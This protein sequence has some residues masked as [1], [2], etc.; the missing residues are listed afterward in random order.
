MHER[1]CH[2]LAIFV[3]L[4]YDPANL[5]AG[6][7]L[8]KKHW[9]DFAKR[10]RKVHAPKKL[11]FFHCGEYGENLSRPHYHAILYGIDFPDKIR[12]SKTL[13]GD[14][15]YES[16]TLNDIWGHGQ[17][18]IGSVT[19][20]SARYVAA[21]C[22]KKVNG[23]KADAHYSRPDADGVLHQLEPE[24]STQSK[25]LGLAWLKRYT[26]DVFPID[27][28]VCEGRESPVPRYYRKKLAEHD[29]QTL[30]A[31]R[32]G[33]SLSKRLSDNRI[34]AAK[35]RAPDNTPE[36]LAVKLTVRLSKISQLKRTL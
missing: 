3:T 6:G 19:F 4:T 29:E 30:P 15:L 31:P 34:K 21:Y 24:Y 22:L 1:Q 35:K 10:L 32:Y 17:C 14:Q 13:Q 26:S 20:K 36:R 27:S 12:Y 16:K 28:V 23:E 2:D 25:G 9:Q 8:V 5:P 11:K 33:R 18:W 7:T